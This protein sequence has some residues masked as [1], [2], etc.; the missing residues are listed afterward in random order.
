MLKLI[1]V[2]E[3]IMIVLHELVDR[4]VEWPLTMKHHL[5]DALGHDRP[6]ES[7]GVRIHVRCLVGGQAHSLATRLTLFSQ[8]AFSST[9]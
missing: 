6:D 3:F 2:A 8:D 5:A 7:L 4:M 1:Q 9:K